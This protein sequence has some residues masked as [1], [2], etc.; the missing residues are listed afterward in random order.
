VA[1]DHEIQPRWR[2][3]RSEETIRTQRRCKRRKAPS[4]EGCRTAPSP[5]PPRRASRPREARR[6]RRQ[7]SRFCSCVLRT[8]VV[9]GR[10]PAIRV[11]SVASYASAP[12]RL[13]MRDPSRADARRHRSR[14]GSRFLV[15]T[16]A[17]NP[18]TVSDWSDLP[19]VPTV[20]A[21]DLHGLTLNPSAMYFR[22]AA[23]SAQCSEVGLAP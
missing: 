1:S 4:K 3:E 17:R 2:C 11:G 22:S 20:G 10:S 18:A 21:T 13:C 14:F 23:R 16:E 5:R 7:R 15:I 6:R 8:H 12:W 9:A 19:G